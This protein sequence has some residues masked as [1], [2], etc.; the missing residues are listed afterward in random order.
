MSYN[1]YIERAEEKLRKAS[2]NLGCQPI[3]F[4]GSGLSKRYTGSPSWDELLEEL[5]DNCDL[6]EQPLGYYKQKYDG[7][8]EIGD[9][10]ARKFQEWAWS[11]GRKNF[12]DHLFEKDVNQ[13]SYIKYYIQKILEN[14]KKLNNKT[15]QDEIEKLKKI[16]PH[17]IITTN[18]DSMIEDIF[19][20]HEKIIGQKILQNT[21]YQSVKYTKYTDVSAILIHLY[22]LKAIM[23]T[24]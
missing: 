9:E 10:F 2:E 15:F 14:Y 5:A 24:S 8:A 12:P 4:I 22:L 11:T 16:R 6:I 18:Y 3:L 19:P 17:A 23:K 13:S 21:L 7:N 1:S 20:D